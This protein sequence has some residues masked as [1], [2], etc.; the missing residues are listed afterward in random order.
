MA[1]PVT[2]GEQDLYFLTIYANATGEEIVFRY[3]DAAN[4]QIYA[5]KES[6]SFAANALVGDPQNPLLFRAAR[7]QCSRVSYLQSTGPAAGDAGGRVVGGRGLPGGLGWAGWSGTTFGHGRL[8][9]GI[10][11]R[12][13]AANAEADASPVDLLDENR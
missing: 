8:S 5:I 6:L 11:G 4:D 13:Y 2:V 12:R 1:A 7:C 9:G 3:Y 10:A